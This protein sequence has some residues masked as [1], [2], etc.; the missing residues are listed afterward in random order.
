MENEESKLEVG[1]GAEA[2]KQL[3][4]EINIHELA[5]EIRTELAGHVTSVQR[6]VS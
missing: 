5:D 4:G 3:L 1:I 2:I 6:K